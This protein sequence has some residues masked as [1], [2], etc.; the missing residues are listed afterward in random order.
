MTMPMRIRF[1][2][3]LYYKLDA[4][5]MDWYYRDTADGERRMDWVTNWEDDA[6]EEETNAKS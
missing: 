1:A 6:H 3:W 2:E 4:Y 5:I